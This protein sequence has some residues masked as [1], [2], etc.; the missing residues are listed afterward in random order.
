MPTVADAFCNVDHETPAMQRA[1]RYGNALRL[2]SLWAAH[3]EQVATIVR[4]ALDG[5]D[6]WSDPRFAVQPERDTRRKDVSRKVTE[7]NHEFNPAWNNRA[8]C[9]LCGQ[10]RD[11]HPVVGT[12]GSACDE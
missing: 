10:G 4:S 6:P 5:G 1:D 3:P 8:E 12:I 2:C 9:F 7:A 11:V